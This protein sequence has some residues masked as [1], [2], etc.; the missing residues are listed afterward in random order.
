MNR[1]SEVTHL[2]SKHVWEIERARE[3]FTSETRNFVV[4][5][6][7]SLRQTRSEPWASHRIRINLEADIEREGKV[8]AYLTAQYAIAR[9]QI[10]FK[11]T[12]NF[13]LVSGLNFG[14]QWRESSQEF[15]WHVSLIP[16][17]GYTQLDDVLWKEWLDQQSTP[18]LPGGYHAAKANTVCFVSRPLDP[19]LTP[20]L[21]YNDV[22]QVLDFILKSD[23]SMAGAI[24]LDLMPGEEVRSTTVP[25]SLSESC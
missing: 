17:A 9:A 15:A 11:K 16:A 2:F 14:I 21:A 23:A 6:L 20:D 12:V 10:R 7:Q 22:K 13:V 3:T 8:T 24:G 5:V 18:P 4:A 19:E 25:E 1:L